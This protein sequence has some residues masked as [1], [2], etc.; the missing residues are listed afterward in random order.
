[1][2]VLNTYTAFG[3][4][5]ESLWPPELAAAAAMVAANAVA[6]AVAAAS[7]TA[8]SK[9]VA[10][11]VEVQ[12]TGNLAPRMNRGPDAGAPKSVGGAQNPAYRCLSHYS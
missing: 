5:N 10:V 7:P 1:M 11:A 4:A 8:V 6:V 2:D 12:Q 3:A 9:A